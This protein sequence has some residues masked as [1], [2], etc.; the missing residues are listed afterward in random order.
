MKTIPP[1]MAFP[2]GVISGQ[3]SI[4]QAPRICA[5]F[6]KRGLVI[7]GRSM[8]GRNLP[9]LFAENERLNVLDFE[10]AGGEPTLDDVR[11][12]LAAAK[13]QKSEWIAGIGGGSVM[14]IAKSAAGLFFEE[15]DPVVFHD[16]VEIEKPGIPFIAAPTTAGTGTETTINAVLTNT[17]TGCK[18]SIRSES[19]MAR[20]II[21]DPELLAGTP[22]SVVAHS[23]MDALTQA[24]EAFT[25]RNATKLSDA[26]CLQALE[27][28]AGNLDGLFQN[29]AGPHAEPMLTGSFLAGL[30]LSMA[31]LGVVHGLAHPLGALFHA[32]HGLVCALCLP[33]A[34]KLNR[35]HI[36]GK[37]AEM[38]RIAGAD[39]LDFTI[40]LSE[41][42]GINSPF[43]GR[44]LKERDRVIAETLASGSTKANPK[45]VSADDVNAMLDELFKPA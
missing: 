34:L 29:P 23:G 26:I 39:F 5:G 20:A 7:R 36:G 4:A 6:G 30:G 21:L 41:K 38:S 12:A 15:R 44:E 28:I 16:G 11:A 45:T 24:A 43:R 10:H 18:K 40:R 8:R 42:L 31:R 9:A 27:L 1:T 22:S 2:G 3:G 14:D 33:L 25:S 32:P 17:D 35:G 19:L 13:R 37:Y